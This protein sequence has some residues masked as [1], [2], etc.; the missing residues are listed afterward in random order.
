MW[1]AS[2]KSETL[3][4]APELGPEET[5]PI[6]L[7]LR[8]WIAR[9]LR[10]PIL[11]LHENGF[12]IAERRK[13]RT[14]LYSDI[15]RLWVKETNRYSNGIQIGTEYDIIISAGSERLLLSHRSGVVSRDPFAAFLKQLL[16]RGA[17]RFEKTSELR[18][19]DWFLDSA[20]FHSKNQSLLWSDIGY[21]DIIEGQVTIW[22]RQETYPFVRIPAGSPQA[23]ILNEVLERYAEKHPNPL[24]EDSIGRFLFKRRA[25]M[26]VFHFYQNGIIQEPRHVVFFYN[27]CDSLSFDVN[28][29]FINGIYAFTRTVLK[30]QDRTRTM[31][32]RTQYFGNDSD[33]EQARV[34]ISRKIAEKL[35]LKLA[36][37]EEIPWGKWARLSAHEVRYLST[38]P[39]KSSVRL[40]VPFTHP[41][42]YSMEAGK[43][44]LFRA[45]EPEPLFEM[46]C[47]EENFYPGFFL[48][49]KLVSEH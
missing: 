15:Q 31:K 46:D 37:Q 21:V 7:H 44:Y 4:P 17:D 18:A 47:G 40:S 48:L 22:R 13:N 43:F 30:L 3:S 42:S 39:L 26:R 34:E 36:T 6:P 14:V 10:T 16:E 29:Q 32:F 23:R 38:G 35:Y 8:S 27:R 19:D 25:L 5:A 11:Y 45:G 49:L 33:L 41:I 9:W 24:P 1:R 20:G 28:L 2:L 12:L